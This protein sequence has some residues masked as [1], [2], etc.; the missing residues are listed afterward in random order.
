MKIHGTAK[1]GA[2]SKKDFGVAFG[3]GGA[4]SA[5]MAWIDT[6]YSGS[7]PTIST[8]NETNDTTQPN[9]SDAGS[10][11]ISGN[12]LSVEKGNLKIKIVG[13]WGDYGSLSNTLIGLTTITE[14]S[15]ISDVEM[16]ITQ[17][18]VVANILFNNAAK[19]RPNQEGDDQV[20]VASGD[21]LEIRRDGTTLTW[22]LNENSTPFYT[23][24]GATAADYQVY[25]SSDDGDEGKFI[26]M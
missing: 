19:A 8:T 17:S 15:N 18:Y 4:V 7:E 5:P 20:T 26:F 1:G 21:I 14:A 6:G 9:G 13:D 22:H 25:N 24:T 12:A 3:G 10:G 23:V 11:Y 16:S 2:I